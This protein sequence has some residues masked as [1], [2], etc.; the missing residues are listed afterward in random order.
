MVYEILCDVCGELIR[1]KR[2]LYYKVY[3]CVKGTNGR[4]VIKTYCRP[5]KEKIK[6]LNEE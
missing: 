6:G 3:E 2:S 1:K 5:C 4:E